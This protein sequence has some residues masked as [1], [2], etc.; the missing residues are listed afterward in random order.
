MQVARWA[1]GAAVAALLTLAHAAE[2]VAAQ[3]VIPTSGTSTQ[4]KQAVCRAVGM[5]DADCAFITDI[6][7]LS[8]PPSDVNWDFV[9]APW[10]IDAEG[11]LRSGH[12]T[13]FSGD[14]TMAYGQT[15]TCLRIQAT[16]PESRLLDIRMSISA[17]R[18]HDRL[19][20]GL[21]VANFGMVDLPGAYPDVN[22]LQ[23]RKE[24]SVGDVEFVWCYQKNISGIQGEDAG[25]L[26][27]L[28]FLKVRQLEIAAAAEFGIAASA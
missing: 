25:R 1:R 10:Y 17:E 7:S 19:Y 9:G 6:R 21:G 12:T 8:T 4:V 2:P 5:S 22:H 13:S 20:F 28:R 23:Y 16:L 14:P 3:T 18:T 26:R 15:G 24:L 11:G 27:R